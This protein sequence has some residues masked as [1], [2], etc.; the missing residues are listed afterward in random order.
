MPSSCSKLAD[1]GVAQVIPSKLEA[2]VLRHR[3][4]HELMIKYESQHL[5]FW[6]DREQVVN[7]A[8]LLD[9]WAAA[10]VLL[11]VASLQITYRATETEKQHESQVSRLLGVV[12][13]AYGVEVAKF[14]N[15]ALATSPSTQMSITV[16]GGPIQLKASARKTSIG[17]RMALSTS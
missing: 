1:L 11:D 15:G 8:L 17:K 5:P 7:Q 9:A 2:G 4:V 10:R 16:D 6:Y 14:L 13:E 12:Q 3:L